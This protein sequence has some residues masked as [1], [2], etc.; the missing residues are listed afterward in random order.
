MYKKSENPKLKQINKLA[1]SNLVRGNA[2]CQ[3]QSICQYLLISFSHFQ[4]ITIQ[5]N[6]NR[7]PC[8][9]SIA[10]L[11]TL[12]PNPRTHY[13][14]SLALISQLLMHRGKCLRARTSISLSGG[15]MAKSESGRE[16]R[17]W[18]DVLMIPQGRGIL[19]GG[20]VMWQS[21]KVAGKVYPVC[22]SNWSVGGDNSSEN[23]QA[24]SYIFGLFFIYFCKFLS[25]PS[26]GV[27]YLF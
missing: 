5:W 9:P 10:V 12:P 23:C 19:L 14:R 25:L 8:H 21:G 20:K 6:F 17:T 22:Y 16:A 4:F 7:P 11:A 3:L 13:P 2:A 18:G 24:I 26:M 15:R 1:L 27:I